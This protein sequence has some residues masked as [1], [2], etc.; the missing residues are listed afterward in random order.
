[1]TVCSWRRKLNADGKLAAL[2]SGARLFRPPHLPR[3]F[4]PK[5]TCSRETKSRRHEVSCPSPSAE[6]PHQTQHL[7]EKKSGA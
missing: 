3:K 4:F 5:K 6:L 2:S 1:M 7:A